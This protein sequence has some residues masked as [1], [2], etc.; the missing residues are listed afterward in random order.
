MPKGRKPTHGMSK[1]PTY[2]SWVSM[3]KRCYYPKTNDFDIYGGSGIIVCERWKGSFT[4]FYED[5]GLRPSLKHSIDRL[6]SSGNYEPANC[7]WATP[8]EQ[9]ES[10]LKAHPPRPKLQR[11][12]QTCTAQFIR[13]AYDVARYGG[14]Y[15][16]LRCRAK[17]KRHREKHL[18]IMH[19]GNCKEP[20]LRYPSQVKPVWNACSRACLAQLKRGIPRFFQATHSEI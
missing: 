7:R 6:D 17:Q 5:M 16:S 10:R 20:M 11:V 15:C 1:S 12:C 8:K 3:K 4:N 19:C 18:L 2:G 13:S 14:R 9:C